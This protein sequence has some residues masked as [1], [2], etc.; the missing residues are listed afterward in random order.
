MDIAL[1]MIRQ[2]DYSRPKGFLRL[3]ARTHKTSDINTGKQAN[4]LVYDFKEIL[5]IIELS[6]MYVI[7]CSWTR[8]S[9]YCLY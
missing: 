1:V 7:F 2:F 3:Q 9:F 5:R 4:W 8:D 6:H